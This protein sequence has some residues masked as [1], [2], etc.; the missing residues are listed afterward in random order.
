[1]VEMRGQEA[2]RRKLD[3][4]EHLTIYGGLKEGIEMKTCL[5]GPNGLRDKIENTISGGEPGPTRKKEE[6]Y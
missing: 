3:E 6:I 1:M 2:L 4:E 5:H